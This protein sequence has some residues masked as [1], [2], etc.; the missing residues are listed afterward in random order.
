MIGF[1]AQQGQEDASRRR[2]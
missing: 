1:L 2:N